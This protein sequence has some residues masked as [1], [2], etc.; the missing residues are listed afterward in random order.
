MGK[1]QKTIGRQT[2][3]LGKRVIIVMLGGALLVQPM[4]SILP[5]SWS[6]AA[7]KPAIASASTGPVLKLTQQSFVTAGAKRL[8]YV[9][10][11]TRGSAKVQTAVH[12]IEVDLTNPYVS[13]N[14]ISGKNNSVGQLNTILNM[15]KESGAVAA[16]NA[17][18]F[19]MGNEGAP[20]G[21]QVTSGVFMSSPASLKGMYAF[22]LSKD[23]KPMIDHYTFEG[24]VTA[25]DGSGFPLEG[26]NQ[27]AYAPETTGSKFS[28]VDKMYM[29]TS[30]WGGAERPRNSGTTPTE[31]LV[32]NGIIEEISID[33][34]IAGQAPSDGFILRAHGKAAAY[35]KERLQVGQ[36]LA[37]NY[38]LISQTTGAKVDPV[39]FEMMAG[40]HTL[41]VNAGAAATYSRDVTGISGN[42]YTSRTAVGYSKDGTKVYLITSER[43]GSNTGLSLKE[44]QQIMLQLGVFKG[45]N[46]D[47]G[48]STTMTERPLGSFSLQL[49]HATQSGTTQRSVSNGIGVFTS[50]PQGSL[51]GINISG[52]NVLLIGQKASFSLNAYDTYYNPM[53][54]NNSAA[55]SS[56]NA[57]GTLQGNEFTALKAG[58]TTLSVKSGAISTKHDVEVLGRDQIASLSI[59]TTAGVLAPGVT[60]S[61]PVT[62][63]L[64]NGKSYKLSGDAVQWQFIG[65]NATQQGDS[66]TVTSVNT[67][68]ATGYAI[69]RYDGFATMIP[70]TQGEAVTTLEDFEKPAYA[71]T[72]QVTPT[73]ATGN[74]SLVSNL[75][76]QPSAQAL[77]LDYDF[78]NGTGTKASY[79]IFNS[80]GLPLTGSPTSMTVDLYS[81]NSF[82]WVRAEFIDADGKAHLLDLAKQ[83]DWSG[84]KTVKVNLSSAGMKFP[85]KLK[86]AY[87]VTIAE[88]QDKRALSGS[89]GM[90][91][92]KLQYPPSAVVDTNTKIEMLVGNPNA[93]L[94]G[95]PIKLE[96]APLVLN[97]TTYVPVRFVSDAMGSQVL[98]DNKSKQV[99]VLRGNK[100]LEMTI[101]EKELNLNGV[102]QSSE[103]TPI[104]RNSR[105]L[106]PVRLFSEKLG[107]KVGYEAKQKKIT[108]D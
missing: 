9:W 93:T 84:W 54:L 97:G 79:A 87:I 58:K 60:I 107:L 70:F 75:P 21:A 81:D 27:S 69:A 55:W 29:Y 20:F 35:V 37:A 38:S 19:V 30:A 89:I 63:K 103:I 57:I 10:H 101:G 3:S 16:V 91:N 90:D 31:V 25:A 65:F 46:L 39:S 61:V 72:S 33:K 102:L 52:A 88:G 22:T 98:Y 59:G 8:D 74:V 86:R 92:M 28:H 77:K 11:T 85:V 7:V 15:S 71:I 47:G 106:I 105:T 2:A 95:K 64:K 17:D 99:T 26:L 76:E 49:A 44:L 18:L 104:I 82:N 24:Q 42:S 32:R 108:I 14:A 23:R 51:K 41:L 5:D 68:T 50:A 43:Y 67:G 6:A 78:T 83:L 66:L 53:N 73:G 36:A 62:A 94:N 1:V 45:V 96:A 13:L 100:L 80:T 56:S 40:G 48:G 34:A 12:V 4:A